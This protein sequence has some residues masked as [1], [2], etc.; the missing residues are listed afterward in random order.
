MCRS[1]ATMSKPTANL[2]MCCCR[3]CARFPGAV[4]L[5]IHQSGDYPQFNV[6][7]DRTKAQLV[8]LTEQSVAGN[9]LVS[10]SGSFQTSPVL[11][12]RPAIAALNTRLP[13]RRR[14]TA[15]RRSTIWAIHR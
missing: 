7:V 12:G 2:P 4:D 14:N 1:S 10:L 9:M 13:P 11:L 6:D 5:H 3:N 15:S 8:G